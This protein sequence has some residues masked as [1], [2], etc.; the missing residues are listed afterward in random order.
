LDNLCVA[1]PVGNNEIERTLAAKLAM[2]KE[3]GRLRCKN[4]WDENHPRDWD[5]VRSDAR[6]GGYTVHMGYLFG[7]CV[8]KNA[9]LDH[10]L[11][12][13]KGRV[14]FQ[15]NQVY[16]QDHN[17]AIFQDLGSSL[18]TL[19]AARAVDFYGCLPGHCIEVA[20]AEQAYI[21]A[22]MHGRP[23]LDLSSS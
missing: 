17:Y 18:A 21:Q 5:E 1:R 13:F 4:I 2:Q 16:Y 3:W 11:R 8:E 12:K 6:R 15:G 22:D 9:E 10:S 23:C 20:D 7:I 19:Q 14:V